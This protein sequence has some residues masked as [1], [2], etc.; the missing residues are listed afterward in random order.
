MYS[1]I[2][3][4]VGDTLIDSRLQVPE[5]YC[6]EITHRNCTH[7]II[8]YDE[9]FHKEDRVRSLDFVKLCPIPSPQTSYA[10][11]KLLNDYTENRK[12]DEKNAFFVRW[13]QQGFNVVEINTLKS[14]ALEF[15]RIKTDVKKETTFLRNGQNQ[16]VP[17]GIA[18]LDQGDKDISSMTDKALTNKVFLKNDLPLTTVER[19]SEHYEDMDNYQLYNFLHPDRQ[20]SEDDLHA[21]TETLNDQEE[22]TDKF[23]VLTP[24]LR[25]KDECQKYVEKIGGKTAKRIHVILNV[26]VNKNLVNFSSQDGHWTY[27]SIDEKTILYGD[28]LGTHGIPGNFVKHINPIYRAM[29][30]HDIDTTEVTIK[31][32]SNNVNFP[33][34]TCSTICGLIAA[35]LCI[36]SF[37][38]DLYNEIF[39]SK[40]E[41]VGLKFIKNPS[42]FKEQIRMR[43]LKLISSRKHC[44]KMFFPPNLKF[45][46]RTA[47]NI[48][49]T[50]TRKTRQTKTNASKAWESLKSKSMS[51]TN[52][53]AEMTSMLNSLSPISNSSINSVPI[54]TFNSFTSSDSNSFKETCT[55]VPSVTDSPSITE[56]SNFVGLK[57]FPTGIGYPNNDMFVW[58]LLVA[59]KSKGPKLFV[60]ENANCTAKKNIFKTKV[61]LRN[62]SKDPKLPINVKYI[63]GHS[64][65]DVPKVENLFSSSYQARMKEE[66]FKEKEATIIEKQNDEPSKGRIEE[67]DRTS[68][69]NESRVEHNKEDENLLRTEIVTVDENEQINSV[70]QMNPTKGRKENKV[71]QNKEANKKGL[72]DGSEQID[73][74]QPMEHNDGKT[75]TETEQRD[76]ITNI[77]DGDEPTEKEQ[78][79]SAQSMVR[80]NE[81]EDGN[82]QNNPVTPMESPVSLTEEEFAEGTAD[83]GDSVDRNDNSM[84]DTDAWPEWDLSSIQESVANDKTDD[85]N[86]TSRN[87]VKSCYICTFETDSSDEFKEHMISSHNQLCKIC[88]FATTT[89]ELL[90]EHIS[91]HNEPENTEEEQISAMMKC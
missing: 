46:F 53:K 65:N 78:H 11:W 15:H 68:E 24:D 27:S 59:R 88:D 33:I 75:D 37:S 19:T 51:R 42:Y 39:F 52:T 8:D 4:S 57:S 35:M 86:R 71:K 60:C 26:I 87:E 28:P 67:T 89:G 47:D 76:E 85:M 23:M 22:G 30:G 79:D 17:Q 80:D 50:I 14:L 34:Q 16:S 29:Y 21:V 18:H 49:S 56:S 62:K 45:N 66:V 10:V 5:R 63:T 43:F 73:S 44:V 41:N 25:E 31:N 58:K 90:R 2:F 91:T 36:T 83:I 3:F 81:I 72:L 70:K 40:K 13:G 48:L 32:C 55:I 12:T 69:A 84:N 20:F 74:I 7:A 6:Q 64:C 38:E 82:H 9:N 54:C 1:L 61:E 77:C